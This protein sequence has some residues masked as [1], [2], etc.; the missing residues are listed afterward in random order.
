MRLYS[1]TV[2]LAAALCLVWA[3]VWW[4][5]LATSHEHT[6]LREMAEERNA[7]IARSA[8]AKTVDVLAKDTQEDRATL[9]STISDRDV[10]SI[11]RL[12]EQAAEDARASF[13]VET[14]APE[15]FLAA[16]GNQ[17]PLPA[18]VISMRVEGSFERVHHFLVLIEHIPLVARIDQASI[19]QREGGAWRLTTRVRIATEEAY[20]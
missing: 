12:F 1:T 10:V 18:V 6:V 8:Y 13:V 5:M 4:L 3:G 16:S 9:Q 15:I 2:I 17:K 7:A 14:V 11:I 20:Q 19:E